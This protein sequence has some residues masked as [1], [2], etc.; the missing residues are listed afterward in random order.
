MIE[1]YPSAP[2]VPSPPVEQPKGKKA[3]Q[4]LMQLV[5]YSIFFF[6]GYIAS[7]LQILLENI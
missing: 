5:L 3:I 1:Q 2:V 7:R 6:M 4:I